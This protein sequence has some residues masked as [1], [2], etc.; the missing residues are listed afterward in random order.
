M[1][2]K[3]R[4]I[5]TEEETHRQFTAATG[6]DARAMPEPEGPLAYIARPY[7]FGAPDRVLEQV[8]VL[9]DCG[10]GI[11]DMAFQLGVGHVNYDNQAAAM[12]LF[13][14]DVLPQIRN[15]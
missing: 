11:I 14:R 1:A 4:K 13:A 12:E 9:R 15:W 5:A 10:V 8:A 2:G 6:R 3:F 7:F